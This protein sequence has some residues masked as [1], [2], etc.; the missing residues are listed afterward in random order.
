MFKKNQ[1][2][3]EISKN[4][5]F[6]QKI[7]MFE[8]IFFS[9]KKNLCFPILGICNS[10]RALRFGLILRR[11]ISKNLEK[12]LKVTCFSKTKLFLNGKKK[13]KIILVLP[14]EEIS[15]QPELSSP[16]RFRIEGRSPERFT[17]TE[18]LMS[19]IVY[20]NGMMNFI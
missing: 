11:K 7:E 9:Q 5:F 6:F 8:N 17:R 20:Q 13:K 19:Y 10:T 2:F 16:P 15:L 4:Q 18:I 3:H 14:I 12:S 1:K